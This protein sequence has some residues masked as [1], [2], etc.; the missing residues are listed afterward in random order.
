MPLIASVLKDLSEYE[1]DTGSEYFQKSNLEIT[2]IDTGNFVSNIIPESVTARFNIRFNDK[3]NAS[4]LY[5]I[6]TKI[7]EKHKIQYDLKYENSSNA[8]IQKYSPMM[9]NFVRKVEDVCKITPN[10]TSCG[11]TSDARFIHSYSEV[12][13]FG[14]DCNPAHKINECSKISDLQALYKVYYNFLVKLML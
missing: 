4:S 6:V 7:L 11:G 9:Q 2:S 8:F 3:H 1:F 14:L 13:E 12:I 5:K 10:I